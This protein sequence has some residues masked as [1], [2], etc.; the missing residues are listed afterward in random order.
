MFSYLPPLLQRQHSSP[1]VARPHHQALAIVKTTATTTAITKV[2]TTTAMATPTM[3]RVTINSAEP[4]GP[5]EV[6]LTA[7]CS[8]A[9]RN[10]VGRSKEC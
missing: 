3:K 7:M 2:T 4:V 1:V 6:N 8:E 9:R 10:Q 5:T